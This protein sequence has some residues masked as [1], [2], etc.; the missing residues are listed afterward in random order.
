LKL[1]YWLYRIARGGARASGI[2][3]PLR[4]TLGPSVARFIF[5]RSTGAGQP[6]LINGH[7]M[8]LADEGQYPPFAMATDKYEAGTTRLLTQIIEPGM[9][10][11]DIGAHVG[12]FT[13]LAA[14]QVG[15]TGHVYSFEPDPSNHRLLQQ[16]IDANG[17]TNITATRK[18]VSKSSGSAQLMLSSRDNGTHSLYAQDSRDANTVNVDLVS[19]DEFLADAGWPKVDLIKMDVEGA[20]MDALVGMSRLLDESPGLKLVMEF[21][22]GLLRSASVD[23]LEFLAKP[24]ELGFEV[25]VI[26]DQEGTTPLD[27]SRAPSLTEELLKSDGSVNLYCLKR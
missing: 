2:A 14:Q 9:V 26:G 1:G 16:N 8:I 15:P 27:Q 17:Y 19:L 13:L 24:V 7:Q 25:Y 11:I 22:P 21:N 10:V 18:A 4:A 6:T 20:E 12:Y 5:K 3:G 23:P